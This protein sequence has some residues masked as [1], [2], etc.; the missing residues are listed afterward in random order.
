LFCSLW[1][2]KS[3][4]EKKSGQLTKESRKIRINGVMIRPC[5][6]FKRE[7]VFLLNITGY[8]AFYSDLTTQSNLTYKTILSFPDVKY[9]QKIFVFT[10]RNF[11]TQSKALAVYFYCLY[12][13]ISQLRTRYIR[14]SNHSIQLIFCRGVQVFS[15]Y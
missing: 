6:V 2:W 15:I 10:T 4:Q 12:R 8:C 14:E 1:F 11:L 7:S 3:F 5:I 9:S 13:I